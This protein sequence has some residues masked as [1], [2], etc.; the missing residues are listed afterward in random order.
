MRF[1][2]TEKVTPSFHFLTY[3]NPSFWN[4]K[5]QTNAINCKVVPLESIYG[6]NRVPHKLG[7]GASKIPSFEWRRRWRV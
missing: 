3:L 6:Q 4:V 2:C 5:R 1:N 7:A